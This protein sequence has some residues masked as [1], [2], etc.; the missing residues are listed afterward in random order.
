MSGLGEFVEKRLADKITPIK[1]VEMKDLVTLLENMGFQNDYNSIDIIISYLEKKNITIINNN[2]LNSEI[3]EIKRIK[4]KIEF[5]KRMR[6]IAGSVFKINER[7][8][9]LDKQ[10]FTKIDGSFLDSYKKIDEE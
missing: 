5:H 9:D 7:I 3:P 2:V 10:I 8:S 4:D 1:V 6:N